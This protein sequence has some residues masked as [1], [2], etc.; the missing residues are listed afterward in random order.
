[1]RHSQNI[2]ARILY[3]IMIFMVFKETLSYLDIGLNT[4]FY[5][6]FFILGTA[7]YIFDILTFTSG[8]KAKDFIHSIFLNGILF[9]IFLI[10]YKRSGIFLGFVIFTIVQNL[11]RYIFTK[12]FRANYR[13]AILG[14]GDEAKRIKDIIISNTN[15]NY[16]GFI[17]DDSL[18]S[19]G[20]MENIQEL[21]EK[22][23]I[24]EIVYVEKKNNEDWTEK[25]LN[26]KI[27]GI[28]V[29]DS[30]TFLQESEGKI[31][32][33]NIDRDW[34]LK[35]PGF[36][37]LNSSLE[38]RIKRSFDLCMSMIVLILGAPF[39]ILTY[40]LVKLDNPKKFISNPAFFTQDRIGAGGNE[41]K[42]VK[43]R[44]MRLHD[45]E[46]HSKYAGANDD[47]ITVVG[48]FIRKTRLD[49][50]PQIYNVLRGDM[51]FVGPRPEWNLL[52][53]EYEKVINLYKLRYAV[54]PG[55]TGWA[56]VMYPYGENIDDARIKLEY[57]IYYIKHQNFILD[58]IIFFKTIKTVVF[59][60]GR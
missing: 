12:I 30:I 39:M 50:L 11:L 21:I 44:S 14:C 17:D 18:D 15:Y 36:N 38:Q 25:V 32:V 58:M 34:V 4:A 45:P 41:F 24:N 42:M 26:L 8:Y 16:I 13:L 2:R 43:F 53:R 9:Y 1:M 37:I 19:I 56:Q 54:K 7:Y 5:G 57:D 23:D 31:D 59:G 55:L 60:K 10:F 52:G 3:L 40:I 51:S 48:K 20:R 29:Q 49:E 46:K 6:M 47:R 27:N 35:S 22:Y 28:K 33:E